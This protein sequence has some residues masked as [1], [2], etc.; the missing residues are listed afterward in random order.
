M[1]NIALQAKLW[2]NMWACRPNNNNEHNTD[3]LPLFHK[4]EELFGGHEP[5]WIPAYVVRE[6][7]EEFY[8]GLFDRLR[9]LEGPFL[10]NPTPEMEAVAFIVD[11]EP[12]LPVEQR[13][14]FSYSVLHEIYNAL[15]ALRE[16]DNNSKKAVEN[17]KQ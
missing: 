8:P 17:G 4:V 7:M 11:I 1:N 6:I 5:N 2:R 15:Q 12:S 10:V 13:V 9:L 14:F 16:W 3:Q